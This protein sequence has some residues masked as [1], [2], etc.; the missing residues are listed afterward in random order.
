M[1]FSAMASF[2]AASVTAA[3]GGAALRRVK[4]R[5]EL[6]LAGMPLLFASQQAVEGALW[7]QLSG[8]RSRQATAVLSLIFL[9][10]AKVLWPAYTAFAV[11][12]IEPSPRRRQALYAVAILGFSISIYSLTGLIENPPAAAI[13]GH[14]IDYG[15]EGHAIS[16]RSLLYLL[17]TSVPLMLSSSIILQ[18]LGAMVLAGFLVSAYTSFATFISVWCFFAAAESS[19]LYYYFDRAAARASLRGC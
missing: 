2:S 9:V 19:L 4:S 15:G 12:M 14:S 6:L 18:V 7:L 1:C 13:R 8:E 10:F 11:L 16:W 17:C 3:I 5:R